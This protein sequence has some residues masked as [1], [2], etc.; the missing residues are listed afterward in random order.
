MHTV[1]LVLILIGALEDTVVR[2]WR[3]DGLFSLQAS[4]T[5]LSNWQA[6]GQ[7]QIGAAG[8]TDANLRYQGIRTCFSLRLFSQYGLLRVVPQK[9]FRK[10]QDLLLLLLKYERS[11]WPESRFFYIA[12]L[13]G[14]TQWAPTYSYQGDDKVLPARAV[15][16]APF[17]GQ[18][19]WGLQMRPQTGLSFSLY[20][21]SGRVTYVRLQYLAD[22]G[23]FGLRPALRDDQGQLLEPARLTF[24][25][26]GARFSNDIDLLVLK[27]LRIKY[28]LDVFGSYSAKTWGPVVL[29][30]LQAAY[31]LQDWLVLTLNQQLI[32]D[33][34][35]GSRSQ[36]LQLLTTW[37]L[38]VVWKR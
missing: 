9:Q 19:S 34:R 18:F 5:A 29:S 22:A 27:S 17:Y 10:T 12:A 7:N 6:G 16:L 13:D 2:R 3:F 24:W 28:F 38:S 4:Q 1:G 36:T 23:A 35:V 32:Y 14:R 30:Q 33:P 8:Q 21:L 20:P 31:K 26:L 11:L 25:E 15:F 37:G